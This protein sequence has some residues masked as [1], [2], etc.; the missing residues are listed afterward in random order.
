MPPARN[1]SANGS[2][3]RGNGRSVTGVVETRGIRV[4][5][6]G[7]TS[8]EPIKPGELGLPIELSPWSLPGFT[9]PQILRF[10]QGV[11][12]DD[13]HRMTQRDGHARSM[14]NLLSWPLRAAKR[15]V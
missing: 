15:T 14:L 9:D 11:T 10:D 7:E 13:L 3:P 6:T 1:G 5:P 8:E 2:S 12:L 4:T